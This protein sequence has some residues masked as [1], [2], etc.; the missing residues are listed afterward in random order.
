MDERVEERTAEIQ[1]R[2]YAHNSFFH[3]SRRDDMAMKFTRLP[4][5]AHGM[6]SLSEPFTDPGSFQSRKYFTRPDY[7]IQNKE[8]GA[9]QIRG[10]IPRMRVNARTRVN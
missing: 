2:L 10:Q 1:R 4:K 7:I 3:Y 6:S 9:M 5:D 8:N